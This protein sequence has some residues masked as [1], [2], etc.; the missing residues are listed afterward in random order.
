MLRTYRLK[1]GIN[2]VKQD[3]VRKTIRAYRCTAQWIAAIQWERLVRTGMFFNKNLDIKRVRSL[4]SERYKQTCQYQVV[5]VLGSFISNLQNEFVRMVFGSQLSDVLK[6][7][8]MN[9]NYY[10]KWYSQSPYSIL[11]AKLEVSGEDL[12]LARRIFKKVLSRHHRPSFGHINMALD[13]KVAVISAKAEGKAKSFDYWVRLSTLDKGKP[14]MVPVNGNNFYD[15][16]AG[17]R[18]KF[19]Q[20]NLTKAGEITVS[21]VKDVPSE[22]GIYLPQTPK[23]ALDLGLKTLFATDKGD[24]LGRRFYDLL[25]KYD[26]LIS[27]LASNRQRQGL[28]VRSPRYDN[29]VDHLRAFMKNEINRCLNRVVDL[30]RPA[31][32]LVER[33]DFRNPDLSRRMNRLISWFGK[34]F[35]RQKLDSL[36]EKLGIVITN[37][38]AAYSSQECS[39]CGYVDKKNRGT[40]AIFKCQCCLTGLHADVNAARNHLSRSSD[41]VIDVY[42]SKQAVLRILTGRFLSDAERIPRLCSKAK[43]LLPRNPYFRECLAQSKGFS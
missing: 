37:T 22:V 35:A 43:D 40:Q 36:H 11:K 25:N 31:E 8:L 21:F 42:K 2:K 9:V 34:S 26:V 24:L 39:V 16:I 19:C 30:Y 7:K 4:L 33:L 3:D 28:P 6:Q 17:V 10:Q 32:I 12:K 41:G 38:N 23:I 20:V 13:N 18:K 29:L 5:G 15:G 1:H 27:K 14:I